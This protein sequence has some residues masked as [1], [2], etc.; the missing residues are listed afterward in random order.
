MEASEKGKVLHFRFA[1]YATCTSGRLENR[2]W[3]TN[4]YEIDHVSVLGNPV[5]EGVGLKFALQG[6]LMHA[7][8][9]QAVL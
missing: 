1:E 8:I 2:R 9:F 4:P 5:K 7:R 6:F 3:K